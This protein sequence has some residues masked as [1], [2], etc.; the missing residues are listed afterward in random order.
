MCSDNAVMIAVAALYAF[1][2]KDANFGYSKV[3]NYANVDDRTTLDYFA[4]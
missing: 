2:S 3:T 4:T 1:G